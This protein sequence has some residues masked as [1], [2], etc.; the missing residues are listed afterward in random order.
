MTVLL[1][2]EI[3]NIILQ[4]APIEPPHVVAYKN[5][6]MRPIFNCELN[7]TLAEGFITLLPVRL[8]VDEE[9]LLFLML[10]PFL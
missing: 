6:T 5:A 8:T 1:P 4:F 10:N 9:Y 2:M 7:S 3:I